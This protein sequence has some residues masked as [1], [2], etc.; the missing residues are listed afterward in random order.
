M[1]RIATAFR[2]RIS[3]RLR[4]RLDRLPSWVRRAVRAIIIVGVFIVILSLPYH[5]LMI[6]VE[7]RSPRFV[8]SLQVVVE[9]LTGTGYGSDS[10][11]E[12]RIANLFVMAM[13]LSTF[14]ILFVVFPYVFRPVLENAFSPSV[15]ATVDAEGH[16]IVCGVP[17]L[18]DQLVAEL[19]TRDVSVVVIAEEGLI[20]VRPD[21]SPCGSRRVRGHRM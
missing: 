2:R 8:H 13:D 9:T 3:D 1:N 14:L 17:R 18:A 16:V 4:S 7:A 5:T 21:R 11:W 12:T 10:P 15:P 6:R 19:T 20:G